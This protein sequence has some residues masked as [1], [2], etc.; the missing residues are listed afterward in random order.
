MYQA[1]IKR[2][3]NYFFIFCLGT[4][5]WIIQSK[6]LCNPDV[7][8][9]VEASQR[10]L[11]GG[12]YT[13]DFFENNPPW[14]LYFN[15]PAVLLVKIFGINQ[16]NAIKIYIYSLI[17]ISLSIANFLLQRIFT[18][19]DRILAQFFLIA[20]GVTFF[21]FPMY[22][23]GQR[24]HLLF[25]LAVP[26]ILMM[27]LRLQNAKINTILAIIIG[28]LSG[29]VFILKPYFLAILCLIEIY[30]TLSKKSLKAW[31][32]PEIFTIFGLLAI[33]LSLVFIRHADYL[34]VVIPHVIH[35]VYLGATSSWNSLAEN[36]W[37]DWSFFVVLFYIA[38]YSINRYKAL[39]AVLMISLGG[40]L[41]SYFAQRTAYPYRILPAASLVLV[42]LVLFF[43]MYVTTANKKLHVYCLMT[44]I[45]FLF[46]LLDNYFQ[47][48][49]YYI[50]DTPA[51]F[52]AEIFV[53]FSAIVFLLKN[54]GLISGSYIK[55]VVIP[56]AVSYLF[57]ISSASLLN[58]NLEH[59]IY[60]CSLLILSF[61]ILVPGS[62]KEKIS[63]FLITLLTILFFS[64]PLFDTQ[65][66]TNYAKL[67]KKKF[68]VLITYLDNSARDQSV[69]IFSTALTHS[70]PVISYTKNTQSAS[71]L[72]GFWLLPGLIKQR[73]LPGY[74]N[75][76][77]QQIKD[78]NF[79]IEMA[80]E[81]IQ[82]KKP[83]LLLFDDLSNKYML[84]YGI[85]PT[86]IGSEQLFNIPYDFVTDFSK[87]EKFR[88]VFRNYH[89]VTTLEEDYFQKIDP[90]LYEFR[91][92]Y[93]RIPKDNEVL[94]DYGNK[95]LFLYLDRDGDLE[96]ALKKTLGTVLRLKINTSNNGL[97]LEQIVAI[98]KSLLTPGAQLDKNDREAILSLLAKLSLQQQFY[99]FKVYERNNV[100]LE[101]RDDKV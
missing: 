89:Y 85:R 56:I 92:T 35:W 63:L 45:L 43:G 87:N 80:V 46:G 47:A 13:K 61:C 48:V 11:A 12:T 83:K 17:L 64:A 55:I 77:E 90:F 79:L 42:I 72:S 14:I 33:Y 29:S 78:K 8:W 25:I 31:C 27:A 68:D 82:S 40:F 6:F 98:K 16:I 67:I 5:A 21:I 66:K 59:T 30:Y 58:L 60:T 4:Y 32:R 2:Y 37:V 69:Y 28:V 7:S 23:F 9:F 62:L 52:F 18:K 15:I 3:I 1:V 20:L 57:Y 26:Y 71:R 84:Y 44:L 100:W 88:N 22:E 10:M 81:D 36:I 38:T 54:Q 39:S 75:L 76:D 24:E 41:F 70:Y 95:K 49:S 99:R 34:Y 73:Y 101:N 93:Q 74:R 19:E 51:I 96:I 91:V 65:V 94:L 97:S 86:Q 50:H 53:I